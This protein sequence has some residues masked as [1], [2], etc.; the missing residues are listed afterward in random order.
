MSRIPGGVA[1]GHPATAA[2]G[3]EVLEAGG[4]ASDSV[5]AMIL[6]GSVAETIFCG[7]N[8]G[9]F[10][11]VYQADTGAVTCLDFFVAVPG[12]DGTVPGPARNIS[13]SFGAVP[14]PYSMGGPT[15]AVGGAPWGAAELNRRF[16]QLSWAQVVEPARALAAIGAPL[17]A[18]HAGLLPEVAPAMLFGAGVDAYS[19]PDGAGGRR[20]LREGELLFH[21]ELASTLDALATGGPAELAT[22]ELGRALVQAV[23][24]DG[25]SLSVQDMAAYRVRELAP[26]QVPFGPGTLQVRGNDLDSFAAAAIALDVE[27]VRRGGAV[28]VAALVDALR[29]PAR[30]SETTSVVAVD[31]AGNACA[32]THSLGL[33]SGVWVGGVHCNSMLGEGELLRAELV[34]GSR[35]PSMMVPCMVTDPAGRLLFAGGAAGGSRIR[36]ALLQVLAGVLVEGRGIAESVAAPRLSATELAVHLE[37]GFGAEVVSLLESAGEQ[38]VQWDAPR[39]YFGGVAAAAADGL[40]GDPRRGGTALL[41]DRP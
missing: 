36:P 19:R 13:I 4:S 14:L 22:G 34:P 3:L 7:L 33:G 12:L 41:L 20:L 31:A 35:M 27:A 28:R 2:A 17:S 21:P 11:T 16:G 29:A 23:R 5:A 6:A 1:A 37:P 9:G 25:G 15:V 18:A 30:R 10:A 32:A 38:V 26:L 24:A 40:A 39:P 8:G